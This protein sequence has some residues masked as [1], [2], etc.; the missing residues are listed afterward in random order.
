VAAPKGKSKKNKSAGGKKGMER[1]RKIKIGLKDRPTRI[2][3]KIIKI[4][5]I[6]NRIL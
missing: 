6:Y 2:L 1:L 3:K 4:D 5:E